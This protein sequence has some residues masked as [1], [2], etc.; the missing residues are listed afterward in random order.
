MELAQ[1][2]VGLNRVGPRWSWPQDRVG[3]TEL[4]QTELA[5]DG[6][7]SKTELAQDGVGPRRSWLKPSWPKM[8]LAPRQSWPDG[9]GS[10]GVGP[11][12]SWPK[13][14]LAPRRSWPKM[15]LD[16]RSWLQDGV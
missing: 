5:Q 7:G 6:V 14:E 15:E 1:D 10:N 13:T 9:V 11:R 8:E 4:A 16:R 2:G 12:R 3:Q